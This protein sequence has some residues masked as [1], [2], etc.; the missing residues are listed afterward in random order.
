MNVHPLA[1]LK[2][3]CKRQHGLWP[4]AAMKVAKANF[5]SSIECLDL[6]ISF[7]CFCISLVLLTNTFLSFW[8]VC[9]ILSVQGGCDG[10]KKR[11]LYYRALG[12]SR[13]GT[14]GKQF[15]ETA[16]LGA[17]RRLRPDYYHFHHESD[18]LVHTLSERWLHQKKAVTYCLRAVC[19]SPK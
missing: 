13:A 3:V 1:A 2:A 10:R 7:S 11:C 12:K 4:H 5:Q 17:S 6:G 9:S 19:Y 16:I 18:I 8:T 15:S 14:K